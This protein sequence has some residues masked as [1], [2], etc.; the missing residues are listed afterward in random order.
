M[1]K[2]RRCGGCGRFTTACPKCH[3][4]SYCYYCNSCVLHGQ[5]EPSAELVQQGREIEERRCGR[6]WLV[7]VAF[8][9]RNGWSN[10]FDVRVRAKGLAG[11]MWHGVREA[12]R[13]HLPPR[14]VVRQAR[15]TIIA[16]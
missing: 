12:R 7:Q 6:Q 15:A 5:D 10:T 11:A 16:A 9:T 2:T 14:T 4:R 1:T 8:L 13:Q 3:H